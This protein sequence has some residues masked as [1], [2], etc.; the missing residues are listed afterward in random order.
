MIIKYRNQDLGLLIIRLGLAY[1]FITHSLQKLAH[2]AMSAKLFSH[3]GLPL[4]LEFMYFICAVE[5]IGGILMLLGLWV[6]VAGLFLACDMLGVIITVRMGPMAHGILAGHDF[7]FMLMLMSL[8]IVLI[9]AGNYALQRPQQKQ[10][11]V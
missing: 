7:E 4:P 10:M 2:P 5:L 6:D 3:L 9:G 8:T 11:F 1:E